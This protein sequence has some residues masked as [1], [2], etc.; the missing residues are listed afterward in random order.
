MLNGIW[1][2]QLIFIWLWLLCTSLHG[3]FPVKSHY[4]TAEAPYNPLLNLPFKF[5]FTV[6]NTHTLYK[7]EWICSLFK[8]WILEKSEI[9][10][11]LEWTFVLF[12]H[13]GVTTGITRG[14][15][16]I[17]EVTP[18]WVNT[19]VH[20]KFT[21]I[22]LFS[23]IHSLTLKRP[24]GGGW[25]NPPPLWFFF[26]DNFK[27]VK[28]FAPAFHDFWAPSLTH[29]LI[30]NLTNLDLRFS[31]SAVFYSRARTKKWIFPY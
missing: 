12:T 23:K 22:S 4:F 1:S 14:F 28:G 10:V 16:V 31:R 20:S 15:R 30:P 17:P 26:R 5:S 2:N 13:F 7:K 9:R 29:R 11:H 18:K 21:L 6:I 3:C 19:N 8:E 24:G 25:I 27:T